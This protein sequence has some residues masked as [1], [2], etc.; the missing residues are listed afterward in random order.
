M[1][2]NLIDAHGHKTLKENILLSDEIIGTFNGKSVA[3][4][5]IIIKTKKGLV[6]LV[7]CSH[8]GIVL[9]VKKAKEMFGMPIYG[10]IGG[11]HLVH[12]K[13]EEILACVNA[14]KNEGVKMVAPTH[15]TGRKAERFF[16]RVFGKGFVSIREGGTITLSY[17]P[18]QI[19]KVRKNR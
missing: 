12:A 16:R 5:F 1:G 10:V 17:L 15:C 11:L 6:V 7:G 18:A 2:G 19:G 3:E 9:I 13:T 14:L 8:H 4:K